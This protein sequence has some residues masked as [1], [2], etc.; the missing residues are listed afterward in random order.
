MPIHITELDT[1]PH[2][3]FSWSFYE[4]TDTPAGIPPEIVMAAGNIT[5]LAIALTE[6]ADAD[7]VVGITVN[8][9]TLHTLTLTAS[10]GVQVDDITG[11]PIAVAAGDIVSVDPT[12]IPGT[13][14]G[15]WGTIVALVELA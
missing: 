6:V 11:T 1:S 8:G 14:P 13:N 9:T 3:R 7:I 10:D 5:K 4:H 2:T 12:S 15:R